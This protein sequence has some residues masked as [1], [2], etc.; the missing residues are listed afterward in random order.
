MADDKEQ[1]SQQADDFLEDV[2][3]KR[4]QGLPVP[5][6]DW[7]QPVRHQDAEYL[8]NHYPFL[9]IMSTEPEFPEV[10]TPQFYTASSGWTIHDYGEAM[11]SSPGKLLFGPGAPDLEE[12]EDGGDAGEGGAGSTEFTGRGTV[13][14]QLF[15][16]ARAMMKLITQKN[17]PGIDI[18]A[19]TELMKWALWMAAED[20]G[21]KLQG[22][23]PSEKDQAKRERIKKLRAESEAEIKPGMGPK[24]RG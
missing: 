17:W 11:S 18:I 12:K 7:S 22:F 14:K 2:W 1:F 10:I 13:V 16:T 24:G 3:G 4:E 23:E 15:D 5:K 8:R 19:G 9:Q 20:Q 6:I 21:Y